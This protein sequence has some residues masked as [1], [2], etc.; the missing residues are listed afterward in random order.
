MNVYGFIKLS[1]TFFNNEAI[2]IIGE[3]P[4]GESFTVILFKLLCLAGKQNNGGKL[5]LCNTPLAPKTMATLIRYPVETVISALE[6]FISLGLMVFEDDSYRFTEWE[7]TYEKPPKKRTEYYREYMRKYRK[8]HKRGNKPQ[9]HL[10][11]RNNNTTKPCH[12]NTPPPHPTT[13]YTIPKNNVTY[14]ASSVNKDYIP[15]HGERYRYSNIPQYISYKQRNENGDGLMF[16]GPNRCV[17][18]TENQA[19]DLVDQLGWNGSKYYTDKLDTFIFE[20]NAQVKNHYLTI[21]KWANEDA[22]L[23]QGKPAEPELH[24]I[25]AFW[26][27]PDDDEG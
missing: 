27:E 23:A 18:M 11:E 5:S 4:E 17:K 15:N 26:D 21:L 6:T 3:M 8:E 10:C 14:S 19:C 24:S 16:M 9:K 12:C 25:F 20:K 22:V 7:D 1:P 2:E 13:S